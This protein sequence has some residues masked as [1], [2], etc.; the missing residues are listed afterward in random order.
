MRKGKIAVTLD[1]R[2]ISELDRLVEEHVYENRSQAVQAA[3]NEK[4]ERL[5][6]TRLA[7]ESARL[8]PVHERAL[9][10]EGLAAD[11]VEW[12]AY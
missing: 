8:N 1:N 11:S 10:E 5:N 3:V 9:A 2:S 12:P 6:K 4:L 7:R